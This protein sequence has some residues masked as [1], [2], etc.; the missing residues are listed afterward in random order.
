M[1]ADAPSATCCARGERSPMWSANVTVLDSS[2]DMWLSKQISYSPG[3]LRR[4]VRGGRHVVGA[5][6]SPHE[7]RGCPEQPLG[8]PTLVNDRLSL[9]VA[10]LDLD[11]VLAA[12]AA[13]SDA[14]RVT[15][16]TA[17]RR[18]RRR[19]DLTK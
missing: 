16:G 11:V 4:A 5:A 13:A 17:R 18:L 9:W 10:H 19:A 15:W 7:L 14:P 3:T 6:R 1:Q 2:F 12:G 8:R